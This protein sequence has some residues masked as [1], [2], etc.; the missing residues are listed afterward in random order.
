ML[1]CKIQHTGARTENFWDVI[2]P[3][4]LLSSLRKSQRKKIILFTNSEGGYNCSFRICYTSVV[5]I[6]FTLVVIWKD[7]L[8]KNENICFKLP[9]LPAFKLPNTHRNI[10][11]NV[12]ESY[13]TV[14]SHYICAGEGQGIKQDKKWNLNRLCFLLF[15]LKEKIRYTMKKKRCLLLN[16]KLVPTEGLYFKL[17]LFL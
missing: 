8:G 4:I 6:S 10:L 3:S 12:T 15:K 17:V 5:P 13:Y 9:L 11:L 14:S 2:I 1:S 16:T 7:F